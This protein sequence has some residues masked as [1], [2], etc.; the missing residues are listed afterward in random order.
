[1]KRVKRVVFDTSTLIGAALHPES[2]PKKALTHAFVHWHVCASAETLAE[3]ETVLER[4]KFNR[5]LDAG[6]REEFVSLIRGEVKLFQGFGDVP[7]NSSLS[8]RDPKDNKFLALAL[9]AEADAIV[10]SDK[11]LLVLHPWRGIRIVTPAEFLT[12]H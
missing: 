8:C 11:D 2:T 10:S 6:S 9:A 1:V 12:E 7:A 3:L 4:T 5:Y